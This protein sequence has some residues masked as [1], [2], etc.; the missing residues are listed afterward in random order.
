VLQQGPSKLFEDGFKIYKYKRLGSFNHWVSMG[1]ISSMIEPS[2]D[3]WSSR[4]LGWMKSQWIKKEVELSC[5]P[6]NEEV[7]T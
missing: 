1:L 6:N 3:E 4:S 7:V 2:K 5:K